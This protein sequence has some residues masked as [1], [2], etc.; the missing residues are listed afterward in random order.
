MGGK[1]TL[2][3]SWTIQRLM[4]SRYEYLKAEGNYVNFTMDLLQL[5]VFYYQEART[6]PKHCWLALVSDL[7]ACPYRCIKDHKVCVLITAEV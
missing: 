3:I 1:M 6:L 7:E 5:F 2:D 4:Q